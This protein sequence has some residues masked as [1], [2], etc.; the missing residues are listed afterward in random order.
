V[1]FL[2]EVIVFARGRNT[3]GIKADEQRAFVVGH[4]VELVA[5]NTREP[6]LSEP[7]GGFLSGVGLAELVLIVDLGLEGL[8]GGFRLREASCALS[9]CFKR[10]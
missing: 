7:I 4:S 6:S 3:A 1:R 10:I 2:G 5:L 9:A 8:Q